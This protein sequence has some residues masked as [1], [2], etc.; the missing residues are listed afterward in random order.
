MT[1]IMINLTPRIALC[2]KRAICP[3][4]YQRKKGAL[5]YPETLPKSE[6]GL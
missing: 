6:A 1:Q 3:E 4:A 2:S 5:I